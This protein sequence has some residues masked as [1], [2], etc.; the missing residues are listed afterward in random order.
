MTGAEVRQYPEMPI[1]WAA[2]LP[3][4]LTVN[5]NV[6]KTVIDKLGG[7]QLREIF[8]MCVMFMLLA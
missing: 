8:R 2:S 1:L 7:G 6:R 3:G 5:P 4:D